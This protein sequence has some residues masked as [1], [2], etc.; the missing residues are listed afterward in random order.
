VDPCVIAASSQP[1]SSGE[2]GLILF[3]GSPGGWSGRWC[4]EDLAFARC[5]SCDGSGRNAGSNDKR[6]GTCRRCKGSGKR[7][8][9]AVRLFVSRKD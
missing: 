8:R 3:L 1:G 9:L 5:R 2:G 7:Q 4:S 6:W